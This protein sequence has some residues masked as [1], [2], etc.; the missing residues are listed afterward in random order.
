MDIAFNVL[1]IATPAPKMDAQ[2]VTQGFMS[3]TL[4]A[5]VP[6]Q[7]R[8]TLKMVLLVLNVVIT[9][10]PAQIKNAQFALPPILRIIEIVL[11]RAQAANI[12][13]KLNASLVLRHA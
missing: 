10:M 13:M 2:N 9:V 1:L 8:D 5:L 4:N 11:V 6:A 12:A 3:S 7:V